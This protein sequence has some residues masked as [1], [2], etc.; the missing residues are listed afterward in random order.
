M[1]VPSCVAPPKRRQAA[2]TIQVSTEVGLRATVFRIPARR[3]FEQKLSDFLGLSGEIL[4]HTF[5]YN[6]SMIDRHLRDRTFAGQDICGTGHLRDRT[7]AGQ[8]ICGTSMIGN[9]QGKA[10]ISLDVAKRASPRDRV[11]LVLG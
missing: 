5:S 8:D 11:D 7:F 4:R 10:H 1:E 3:S 6:C 9:R 2:L